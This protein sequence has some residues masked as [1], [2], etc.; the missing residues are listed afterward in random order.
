VTADGRA[1]VVVVGA[2]LAGLTAA[3]SLVGAGL[4]VRVV[5]AADGIGGRVRTDLVDGFRLDRGFQVMLT[6]YPTASSVLDMRALD[7]RAFSPGALVWDGEGLHRLADPFR[8]PIGHTIA[9]A[10][11][12]VGTL[13]DKLRLARFRQRLLSTSAAGPAATAEQS[14][15]SWLQ[16][17]GFSDRVIDAFFRPFLGGV[18]LDPDL[19]TSARVTRMLMRAFF[20]GD[21]AVPSLGMQAISD[22]LAA[23]LDITLST[24][25]E[26]LDGLD[27]D[28]VVVATD[29][30]TAAR[31]I[32][33]PALDTGA[34]AASCLY[35]ASRE[36]PTD[37]PTL[38]LTGGRGGPVTFVAVPSLAA[39][40]YAPAGWHL[41]AV[42]FSGE[43]ATGDPRV[44]DAAARAQLRPILGAGVDG[45]TL[46][47]SYEIPHGQPAQVRLPSTDVRQGRRRYLAGDHTTTAS[48]EG[49]IQSGIVAARAVQADLGAGVAA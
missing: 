13:A 16:G 26:D 23:G 12:P 10:L 39:P 34:K 2:G 4:H 43:A 18:L 36:A 44:H 25:V 46:I 3:R 17:E 38:V 22:Q 5:D 40:T 41:I 20:A 14:T 9:A 11:A 24:P 42:N 37:D 28:A 19:R 33:R 6:A 45:W 1:D 27:A 47:D 35:Y 8:S 15:L 48:I 32:G 29:A 21:A 7:L 31:L 49:A 30:P